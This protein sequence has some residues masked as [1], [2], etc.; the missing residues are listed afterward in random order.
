MIGKSVARIVCRGGVAPQDGAIIGLAFEP[1]IF[2]P[3]YIYE[4]KTFMDQFFIEEI[5][6]SLVTDTVDNPVG[7]SWSTEIGRIL[8]VGGGRA[9]MTLDEY[10]NINKG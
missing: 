2:K 1:G 7:I 9:F 6:P 4:I 3:G 8:C 10:K 5:G